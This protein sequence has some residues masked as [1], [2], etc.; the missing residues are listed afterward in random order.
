MLKYFRNQEILIKK[1]ELI[2]SDDYFFIAKL[3][4]PLKSGLVA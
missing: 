4:Y 2:F 1:I 3:Y